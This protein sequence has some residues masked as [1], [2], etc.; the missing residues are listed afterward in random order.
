MHHDYERSL[1]GSTYYLLW[2]EM[3]ADLSARVRG[4]YR[5]PEDPVFMLG[6]TIREIDMDGE[7]TNEWRV[8]EKMSRSRDEV[9][10][11]A[12]GQARVDTRQLYPRDQVGRLPI[13]LQEHEQHRA[14]LAGDR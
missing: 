8:W 13:E 7:T 14:R 12:R 1:T 11:P 4:G 9:I 5:T 6:D 2:E 3:P 10:C